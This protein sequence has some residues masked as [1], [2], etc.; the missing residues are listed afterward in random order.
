M[1]WH[2]LYQ[3]AISNCR[4]ETKSEGSG[5]DCEGQGLIKD[6]GTAETGVPETAVFW[7]GDM[8]TGQCK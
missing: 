1:T 6:P 5:C 3:L 4:S 2:N 8:G 7:D